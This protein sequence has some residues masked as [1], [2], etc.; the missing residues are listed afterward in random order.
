[1][2]N[3]VYKGDLPDNL[4]LGAVVAIDCETMGL[5]PKRDR[6]CVVQ[7]SS[8]DGNAHLVQVSKGQT[9]APNLCRMLEDP[10]VLK[11]FH[12]GRFDIAA[13]FEAFGALTSPVY[14]TKIASRL[15]RTYTDRHGLKNLLQELLTVDI[16]KQQQSS[17]WGAKKLSKAQIE[18]ASSDVLYLHQLRGSLNQMLIREG[19]MTI[20]QRCFDF[21]PTRAQLDLA[22]WPDTDIFAHS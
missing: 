14:C 21:L 20:A 11:L 4:D 8:G 1:M 5:N 6:L 3:H 9:S 10:N 17:D 19:R 18:Y 16:S 7:L 13:M 15:V 2:T 22:G 12:F